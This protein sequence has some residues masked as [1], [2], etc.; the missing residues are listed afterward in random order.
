MNHEN[1]KIL[2]DEFVK[3]EPRNF[4]WYGISSRFASNVVIEVEPQAIH[5]RTN[6]SHLL[7]CSS[8]ERLQAVG[9]RSAMIDWTSRLF[10][11]ENAD[12]RKI[13]VEQMV[14][15]G[16]TMALRPFLDI[17]ASAVMM[18]FKNFTHSK[19]LG[20]VQLALFK[21]TGFV[22]GTGGPNWIQ[23]NSL[24]TDI[25]NRGMHKVMCDVK[26]S[27]A[28][29]EYIDGKSKGGDSWTTY[30]HME[31]LLLYIEDPEAFL[32]NKRYKGI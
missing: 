21:P 27:G 29:Q 2:Y 25:M 10:M 3:N 23:F 1:F 19:F 12:E 24:L 4:C 32:K 30:T 28:F 16:Y 15:R 18:I 31:A 22:R 14:F 7:M 11:A 8:D 9:L 20:G 26:D 13:R 5:S 17:P 6:L